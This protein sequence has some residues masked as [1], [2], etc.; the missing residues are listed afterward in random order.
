[1]TISKIDE[2]RIIREIFGCLARA[3]V[4]SSAPKFTKEYVYVDNKWVEITIKYNGDL[5]IPKRRADDG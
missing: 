5:N 2:N 3:W 1:M 4:L